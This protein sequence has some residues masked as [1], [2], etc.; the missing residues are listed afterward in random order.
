M[1]H[2]DAMEQR[3]VMKCSSLSRLFGWLYGIPINE[4]LADCPRVL[5]DP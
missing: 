1:V 5:F 3:L 4:K 2:A